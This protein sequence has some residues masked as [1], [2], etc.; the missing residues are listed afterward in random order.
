MLKYIDLNYFRQ[1]FSILTKPC[2]L[3]AEKLEQQFKLC[4][5]RLSKKQNQLDPQNKKQAKKKPKKKAKK[6]DLDEED[7]LLDQLIAENQLVCDENKVVAARITKLYAGRLAE[8]QQENS[9]LDE[10]NFYYFMFNTRDQTRIESKKKIL[11]DQ[12]Y[13]EVCKQRLKRAS[14]DFL[15]TL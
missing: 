13:Y 12:C 5:D 15:S 10:S 3:M 6:E 7:F 1:Q 14:Q 4:I 9:V 11:L 2:S 8:V